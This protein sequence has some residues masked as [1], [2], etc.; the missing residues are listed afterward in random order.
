MGAGG[1]GGGN[2]ADVDD[3]EETELDEETIEGEVLEVV[4]QMRAE[5]WEKATAAVN[6][7]LGSKV[8]SVKE[9]KEIHT[10]AMDHE[11]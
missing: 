5:F 3:G 10:R 9:V 6:E 4:A 11:I 8:L 7:K 1:V 2:E